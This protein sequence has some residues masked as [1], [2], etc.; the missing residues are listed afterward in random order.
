MNIPFLACNK[1]KI[2]ESFLGL[3][4]PIINNDNKTNDK[5]SNS[6][7]DNNNS[8]NNLEIIDYP[9]P[10]NF[11]QDEIYYNNSN[12]K[13][14]KT[15]EN[16]ENK[17][18]ESFM[19]VH[20]SLEDTL[21]NNYGINKVTLNSSSGIIKNEDSITQNKI[22]LKNLY[23]KKNT[24]NNDNEKKNKNNNIPFD[25]KI[26]EKNKNNIIFKIINNEKNRKK[27]NEQAKKAEKKNKNLKHRNKINNNILIFNTDQQNNLTER[28]PKLI[29][30]N[31]KENN[32]EI[33]YTHRI[34]SKTKICL[35][36]SK[37]LI[38][39]KTGFFAQQNNKK[40]SL[41]VDTSKNFAKESKNK[42]KI[43]NIKH[44][45][46][47]IKKNKNNNNINIKENILFK[48]RMKNIWNHKSHHYNT[49]RNKEV[50]KTDNLKTNKRIKTSNKKN[51]PS[52]THNN[53]L[54][55]SEDFYNKL[56]LTKVKKINYNFIRNTIISSYSHKKKYN[57]SNSKKAKIESYSIKSYLNPFDNTE[58]K[59]FKI[60][61]FK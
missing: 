14:L 57:Y 32:N 6:S 51:M 53:P 1:C 12:G 58:R 20:G 50:I 21:D 25:E 60:N 10:T 35:K 22:I 33:K 28:I 30:N 52:I 2:S 7:K 55:L 56:L 54:Y 41:N 37:K 19:K 26:M 11:N 9:Y 24:S 61:K 47:N 27:E 44:I 36:K 16:Y 59:I 34:I 46:S 39:N 3:K 45:E 38:K 4:D 17:N 13:N 15:D 49:S 31:Y 8:T 48:K 29:N 43:K 23:F 42:N 18:N 5:I 40:I